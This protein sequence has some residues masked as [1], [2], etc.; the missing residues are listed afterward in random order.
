MVLRRF[1]KT[2]FSLG[3]GSWCR[4]NGIRARLTDS[5]KV[6]YI[7]SWSIFQMMTDENFYCCWD[8][9]VKVLAI[10]LRSYKTLLL[11]YPSNSKFFP[12]TLLMLSAFFNDQKC[13]RDNFQ[14]NLNQW[15]GK[16]IDLDLLW[17]K[18]V[19]YGSFQSPNT[20]YIKRNRPA[21]S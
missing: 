16:D 21:L 3:N 12:F 10:H 1:L 20:M 9:K 15:Q 4:W 7:Y 2:G 8:G 11:G 17:D 6:V 19:P 5:F 13:L 18:L 14:N